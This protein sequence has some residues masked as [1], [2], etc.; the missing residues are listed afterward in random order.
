MVLGSREQGVYAV[1]GALVTAFPK[2]FVV[3]NR[4]VT[5]NRR[6]SAVF[7]AEVVILCRSG[8]ERLAL[9]GLDRIRRVL[10]Q[11]VVSGI[12]RAA[13]DGSTTKRP[14]RTL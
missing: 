2:P 6:V 8:S 7:E 4:W 10:T 11:K 9:A 1:R 14:R 5:Q 13:A 3:A 12:K